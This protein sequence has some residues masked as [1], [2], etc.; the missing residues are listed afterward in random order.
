MPQRISPMRFWQVSAKSTCAGV[1]R[2]INSVRRPPFSYR[3]TEAIDP[4]RPL[5]ASAV[6]SLRPVASSWLAPPWRSWYSTG[7]RWYPVEPK[8][9][10][11]SSCAAAAY[12][13]L[14]CRYVIVKMRDV[15]LAL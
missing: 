3:R 6:I 5:L 7:R 1:S 10:S 12:W 4:H 15:T 13:A 2:L 8:F 11:F 14:H 9:S